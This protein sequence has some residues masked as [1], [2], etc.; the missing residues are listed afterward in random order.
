MAPLLLDPRN[1]AAYD[2]PPAQ[3]GRCYLVASTPRTGST[4]L[5]RSLWDTGRVGAPKEY[6]NPMQ[7]RDWELRAGRLGSRIRHG[8]LWGPLVGLAGRGYWPDSRLRAYLDRVRQRRT[9]ASGWF[10][11]KLHHHHFERWFTRAGR[12]PSDFL[13]PITWVHLRRDD[14]LAQAVSWARALQTGRWASHQRALLPP[15]YRRALVDRC[16]A[17]ID[18]SE[19]AWARWFDQQGVSPLRLTYEDA[20]DGS[21]VRKVLALLGESAEVPAPSLERQADATSEQWMRRWR[22]GR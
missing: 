8:A 13:G 18:R 7:V 20:L 14:R 6:L 3:G 5:C 9:G 12:A 19:L 2:L 11:L 16:L 15:L 4:L 1:D 21:G 10:G 22:A 17:A